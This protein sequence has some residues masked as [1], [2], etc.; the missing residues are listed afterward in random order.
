[1]I[2]P[3]AC[4]TEDGHDLRGWLT[5]GPSWPCV[6]VT[7]STDDTDIGTSNL[8]QG[9]MSYLHTAAFKS[10]WHSADES[11]MEWQVGIVETGMVMFRY[12]K[13]RSASARLIKTK[14]EQK[15]LV[16]WALN[17]HVTSSRDYFI[18][19]CLLSPP[20][21]PSPLRRYTIRYVLCSR[22]HNG[23]RPAW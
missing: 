20:Y 21:Y 18:T 1:M 10:L 8:E 7:D 9:K 6:T 11:S 5:L 4:V 22:L 19:T 14:K 2:D 13:Q 15:A 23:S 16:W 12:W 3:S 17:S